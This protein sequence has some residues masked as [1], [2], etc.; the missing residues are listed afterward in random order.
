MFHWLQPKYKKLAYLF[1][2]MLIILSVTRTAVAEQAGPNF[3]YLPQMSSGNWASSA[4]DAP[5]Y[6]SDLGTRAVVIDSY[7][8]PCMVYGNDHLYFTCWTGTLWDVEMVDSDPGVGRFATLVMEAD[9]TPH[10]AYY[11]E[12]N[13]RLRYATRIAGEWQIEYVDGAN[14][15]ASQA[16]ADPQPVTDLDSGVVET[17]A[18]LAA[19]DRAPGLG[20]G[21][22]P[23]GPQRGLTSNKQGVGGYPSI[24]LDSNNVPQIAY[25]DFTNQ[26]LKYARKSGDTWLS[27]P[28]D[29]VGSVGQYPSLALTSTDLPVISYYDATNGKLKLASRS[30]SIWTRTTLDGSDSTTDD[31][32][33]QYSSLVLDSADAP[34]I[35]YYNA[36]DE[37]LR[38]YRLGAAVTLDGTSIG[39]FASLRLAP[40][41]RPF[42]SYFDEKNQD[43]DVTYLTSLGEGGEWVRQVIDADSYVGRMGSLAIGSDGTRGIFYYHSS[44]SQVRYAKITA[45]ST[46]ISIVDTSTVTGFYPSMALMVGKPQIAY[47]ND[48]QNQLIYAY[49]GSAGWTKT[50]VSSANNSGVHPSLAV[51][52]NNIVHLTYRQFESG[53][54]SGSVTSLRYGF[55]TTKWSDFV[56]VDQGVKIGD[57]SSLKVNAANN[58][59]VSYYDEGNANLKYARKVDGEWKV[60]T[61]D[62]DG[63]VGKYSSL[64]LDSYSLAWISYF[65]D[66][67]DNLKVAHR[68]IDGNWQIWTVDSTG[69]VGM[70]TSIA[71]GPGNVPYVVYRDS[72]NNKLKLAVYKNSA[73]TNEVIDSAG[74]A[75]SIVVSKTGKI[76]ISYYDYTNYDLKFAYKTD[77]WHK[78]KIDEAGDVGLYSSLACLDDGTCMVAYMDST[79]GDLKYAV[80]APVQ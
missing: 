41:G 35:A 21:G 9:N 5:R 77:A 27:T 22:D 39:Q 55:L 40:D 8:V 73:W 46:K 32:V 49:L 6:I 10:I 65:D 18:Q 34:Q 12:T 30:G 59:Y 50:V 29:A 45:N 14:L 16:K 2:A 78:E 13:G 11:D 80:R 57:F 66:S 56:A 38:Y 75:S 47:L 60:T 71:V 67:N 62:A 42:I 4:V 19:A 44:N 58:P 15:A 52:P 53:S 51:S 76:Y 1:L 69:L 64:A 7:N 68:T 79:N 36:T 63:D 61:V 37:H 25:Y 3:I 26:N 24:A 54:S 28:L 17:A 33:G 20:E 70:F 43:L 74:G 48:S 31:V 72:T 23:D